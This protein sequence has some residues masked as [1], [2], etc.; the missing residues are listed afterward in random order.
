MYAPPPS[1][2]QV[3]CDLSTAQ[4][5]VES[6][7]TRFNAKYADYQSSDASDDEK[8]LRFGSFLPDYKE[9]Q[10]SFLSEYGQPDIRKFIDRIMPNGGILQVEQ[11]INIA[12][13]GQHDHTHRYY[14]SSSGN[15]VNKVYLF[16]NYDDES[17]W[18]VREDKENTKVHC[19]NLT[20]SS[21]GFGQSDRFWA[22][23][24]HF[25]LWE[26]EHGGDLPTANSIIKSH[27]ARFFENREWQFKNGNPL[28]KA[29]VTYDGERVEPFDKLTLLRA[30]QKTLGANLPPLM[31]KYMDRLGQ[32]QTAETLEDLRA[33]KLPTADFNRAVQLRGMTNSL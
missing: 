31:R 5:R 17:K 7:V 11:R 32:A 30:M 25:G 18:V 12:Y 23:Y 6:D 19:E 33:L 4:A 1:T 27:F 13:P 3:F 15:G 21:L 29:E 20:Y 9:R 10:S 14:F 24:A 8:F 28:F 26:L 22:Q 16:K 2:K